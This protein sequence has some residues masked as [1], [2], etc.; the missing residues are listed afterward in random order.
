MNGTVQHDGWNWLSTSRRVD[1]TTLFNGRQGSCGWPDLNET[2][3]RAL[4][5]AFPDLDRT[6]RSG[7]IIG[8]AMHALSRESIEL[9]GKALQKH[10]D[11]GLKVAQSRNPE[12]FLLAHAIPAMHS[13]REF[14]LA[15]GLVSYGTSLTD[16]Y[17]QVG[18]QAGRILKGAK[19]GDLPVI[20][21]AKLGLV[22]N[23]N[24]AKTLGLTIPAGML[25]IADEVIE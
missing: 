14:V 25:A 1:A 15:G 9:A 20:Q 5:E 3:P 6:L 10:I 17:R 16:T 4:R 13:S 23:L 18:L 24:T 19:P 22:I 2:F 8:G 11:A 12:E 21:S 7:A